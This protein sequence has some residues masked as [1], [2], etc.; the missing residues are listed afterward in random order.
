MK[1]HLVIALSVLALLAAAGPVNSK[2]QEEPFLR[3]ILACE[4][5]EPVEALI[6]PGG[7]AVNLIV[8]SDGPTGVFIAVRAETA[9]GLIF[10]L[11]A[12]ALAALGKT[13]DLLTCTFTGPVTGR[14]F[15][16]LGFFA[17]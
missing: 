12:G 9:E 7:A 15:T 16:I 10:S 3:T 13:R 1:R 14:T 11:P 17:A 5:Q 4:G 2:P 8:P 6:T